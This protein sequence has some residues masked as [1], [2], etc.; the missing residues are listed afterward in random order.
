M[1]PL[2]FL[3]DPYMGVDAMS[4]DR[5]SSALLRIREVTRTAV[6]EAAQDIEECQSSCDRIG[7]MADGRLTCLGT[8]QQLRDMYARGYRLEFGL[9]NAAQPN[10]TKQL[11]EAMQRHFVAG[12]KLVES[13]ENTVTGHSYPHDP[14]IFAPPPQ[15]VLTYR[16]PERQR[17]SELSRTVSL[18]ERTFPLEYAI[19]GENTLEQVFLSSVGADEGQRR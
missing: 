13:F 16:L 11:K 15:N 19:V 18:L 8:L 10:A 5:I 2:L 14:I 3:D 7:V 9:E 4:R 17:Y 12:V 6:I 1:P